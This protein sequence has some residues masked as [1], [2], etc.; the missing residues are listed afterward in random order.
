[1]KINLSLILYLFFYLL[2]LLFFLNLYVNY[3]SSRKHV[4]YFYI[5]IN[6]YR[7]IFSFKYI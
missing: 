7:Y 3:I 2:D 1:M 6:K 5:V 4:H